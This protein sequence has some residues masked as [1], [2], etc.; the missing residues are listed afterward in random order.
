[1]LCK[2]FKMNSKSF[3]EYAYKSGLSITY[4]PVSGLSDKYTLDGALHDDVLTNKATY[5]IKLNPVTEAVAKSILAEY[6]SKCIYLTIYDVAAGSN[7]TVLTKPGT[8]SVDVALVKKGN[9]EYW[10]L[11]ALTF[12]EK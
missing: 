12:I 8:A 3:T 10:Q 7:V 4:N 5:T 1:M 9:A 11:S 6:R 2:T